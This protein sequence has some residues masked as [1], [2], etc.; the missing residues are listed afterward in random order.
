MRDVRTD[1]R[2]FGGMTTLLIGDF[3]QLGSLFSE[4]F[5]TILMGNFV[6][7]AEN[8]ADCHLPQHAGC[9]LFMKF[10]YTVFHANNRTDE[11]ERIQNIDHMRDPSL[12]PPI[13]QKIIRSLAELTRDDIVAFPH[14][15]FACMLVPG[16]VERYL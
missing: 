10:I 16:N 15:R 11:V 12:F 3:F 8:R 7:H 14:F 1:S 9:L 13:N 5:F 6:A 2:P 4:S